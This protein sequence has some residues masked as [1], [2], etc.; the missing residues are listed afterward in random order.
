MAR[1]PRWHNVTRGS[2]AVEVKVE[3]KVE[4]E[5]SEETAGKNIIN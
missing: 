3:V 2:V 4:E 5:K 1:K